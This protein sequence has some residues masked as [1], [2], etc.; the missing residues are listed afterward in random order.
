MEEGAVPTAMHALFA[1]VAEPE[2][3]VPGWVVPANS[4]CWEQILDWG[5]RVR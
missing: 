1:R 5:H 4:F 2:S 3:T